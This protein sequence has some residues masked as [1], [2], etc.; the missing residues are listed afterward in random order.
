MTETEFHNV[1]IPLQARFYRVA[2]YLLEDRDDADD[3]VQ[4]LYVKLWGLR[5]MLD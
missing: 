4:D 5:D 2:W 1:W 3:A